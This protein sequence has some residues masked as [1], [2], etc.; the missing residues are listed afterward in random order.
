MLLRQARSPELRVAAPRGRRGAGQHRLVLGVAGSTEKVSRV[1]R[2][3]QRE[4]QDG[5]QILIWPV[6]RAATDGLARHGPIR[7]AHLEP[8]ED[9]RLLTTSTT[10]V[11]YNWVDLS[12]N[13]TNV[14]LG[15]QVKDIASGRTSASGY[16]S[17]TFGTVAGFSTNGGST[18]TPITP[19]TMAGAGL[20]YNAIQST[21]SGGT[22]SILQGTYQESDIVIDRPLT[23]TG[24]VD[25]NN[26]L[27]T[28]IVPEATSSHAIDP[29]GENFAGGTH[30]GIIIYSPSVTVQ[31]L[32]VDGN[33]NASLDSATGTSFNYQQGIT[34]LY[35]TQ[36]GGSYNSLHNGTLPLIQLGGTGMP[37]RIPTW[38]CRPSR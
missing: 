38:S 23:L 31:D 1:D 3:I 7:S 26:D 16:G 18:V 20:I 12:Y 36:D 4:L 22:V 5:S 10:Y 14:R 19:A 13:G 6:R 27:L 2:R 21:S 37:N 34:T 30:Q 29:A 32:T 28:D 8:L 15:D 17:D 11:D 25:S 24:T 33:G 35:D 9:R